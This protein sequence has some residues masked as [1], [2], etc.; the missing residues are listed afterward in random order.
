MAAALTISDEEATTRWNDLHKHVVSQTAQA[1]VTSFLARTVRAHAEHTQ[2]P[3]EKIAVLPP[4]TG[5]SEVFQEF[6]KSKKRLI[7]I[8]V[9]N[10]LVQHDPKT[11]RDLDFYLPDDVLELLKKLSEDERNVVY[12]LSSR[13]VSGALEKIVDTLPNVGFVAEDGCYIKAK[14]NKGEKTEFVSLVSNVSMQWKKPCVDLLAYYTERTP[15][16]FIEERG[17][18]IRWRYWPGNPNDSELGWARRQAA[19]AQN[20]IWDSLGEKFGLR[21]VPATRSFLVL[22]QSASRQ[23]AV[24][25]ILRPE[26]PPTPETINSPSALSPNLSGETPFD[27]VMAV[28]NEERLLSRV[29]S[30]PNSVTVSTN[31]KNSNAKWRLEQ[32]SVLEQLENLAKA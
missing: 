15:G 30:I 22:P 20:H 7:L 27:F 4:L 10:T 25:L 14:P 18:S 2:K 5:D 1:F 16:S 12:L 24:E 9:E 23:N 32:K 26:G 17:A 6:Q 21:I 28:G 11:T 31:L 8:G 13:P 3:V 19:E 29:N